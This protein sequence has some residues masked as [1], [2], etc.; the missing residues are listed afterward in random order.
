MI[1]G[2]RRAGRVGSGGEREKRATESGNGATGS[3]P[4]QRRRESIDG[5]SRY[6]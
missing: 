2:G 5:V 4:R 3:L 6:Y 1:D